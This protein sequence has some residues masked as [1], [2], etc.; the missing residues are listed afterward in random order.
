ML[1]DQEN[2]MNKNYN[3]MPY[4]L[5]RAK[6]HILLPTQTTLTKPDQNVN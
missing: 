1:R 4:N 2:A 5:F 3:Q 6:C